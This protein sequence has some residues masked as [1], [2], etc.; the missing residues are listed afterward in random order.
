LVGAGNLVYVLGRYGKTTVLK[1]TGKFDLVATNTLD[2]R[3][4]ASPAVVDDQLFLRGHK[5]LYSIGK[6]N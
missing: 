6:L 3:F 5:S 4:D 2:D 1:R